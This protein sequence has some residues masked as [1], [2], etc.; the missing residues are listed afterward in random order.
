MKRILRFC[1]VL[2]FVYMNIIA[3][4]SYS[5]SVEERLFNN[6]LPVLI[7]KSNQMTNK[8]LI[9]EIEKTVVDNNSDIMYQYIDINDSKNPHMVYATLNSDEFI[10]ITSIQKISGQGHNTFY[11]SMNKEGA[12]KLNGSSLFTNIN[13]YDFSQ[14]E[15][16]NL[17]CQKYYID[18]DTADDVIGDLQ[19][20]G[21]EVEI[22]N[23]IMMFQDISV[24]Q[25]SILPVF[26]ICICIFS[27]IL[28]KHKSDAVKRLKGY[29]VGQLYFENLKDL[30]REIVTSFLIT[31]TVFL[32]IVF[33]MCGTTVID[34]ILFSAMIYLVVCLVLIAFSAVSSL[35]V[36][37][38][39][40]ALD[41]KGKDNDKEFFTIA[42]VAKV[43]F[44]VFLVVSVSN[45]FTIINNNYRLYEQSKQVS[46]TLNSYVTFPIYDRGR[47]T[48]SDDF[49]KGVK[50]LYDETNKNNNGVM[51]RCSDYFTYDGGKTMESQF[52]QDEVTIN[53]NYLK[54]NPILDV[55]NN[56][57]T[58]D[59]LDK[60]KLNILV[61]ECKS[62]RAEEIKEISCE[63]YEGLLYEDISI[64]FYKDDTPINTYNSA[65]N[66]ASYGIIY[67]PIINIYDDKYL[68]YEVLN[69]VFGQSYFVETTSDNPYEELFP[70]ISKAG[71]EENILE[72]PYI[73]T[74][75]SQEINLNY[76][77]LKFNIIEIAIYM[78]GLLILIYQFCRLYCE[79]FKN[80]IA[81]KMLKGYSFGNIHIVYI[82]ASV[83]VYITLEVAA[84]ILNILGVININL[85]ILG[86]LCLLELVAFVF[87]TRKYILK[88]IVGFMKGR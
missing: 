69:A 42:L 84:V 2:L 57:I 30:L 8:E 54:I 12:V 47:S 23:E 22:Q 17:S 60:S 53:T 49:A 28:S 19:D 68:E 13:I 63:A 20:K 37:F 1:L 5:Y 32:C 61:P 51:M 41:I 27:Y 78:L 75:F 56:R 66:N 64:I 11:S 73:S 46:S 48:E 74:S 36:N 31:T 71:L 6:K 35:S 33:I 44:F 58:E 83:L 45:S 80:R 40:M 82:I 7:S 15:K 87:T 70:I 29:G 85:V 88:N 16:Y 14:I 9:E 4:I 38:K 62:S 39:N 10:S 86:V 55:N 52:G 72:V 26:L 25:Y 50:L 76:D 24:F 67:N 59:S 21:L 3:F 43:V 81:V 77:T 18:N 34:F 65:V 79:C